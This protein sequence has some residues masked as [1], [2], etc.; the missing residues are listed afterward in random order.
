MKSWNQRGV[1]KEK[2]K[3]NSN[4]KSIYSVTKR[5]RTKINTFQILNLHL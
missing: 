5:P 1:K 2:D 3:T 4:K